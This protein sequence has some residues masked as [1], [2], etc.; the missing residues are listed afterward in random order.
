MS[1]PLNIKIRLHQGVVT[2][3]GSVL[4]TAVKVSKTTTEEIF[5]R[6]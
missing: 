2:P 1:F 6:S 4:T 5:K 3:I